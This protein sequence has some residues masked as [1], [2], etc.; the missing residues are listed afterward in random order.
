MSD[1]LDAILDTLI[2]PSGDGRMPGAGSL[3]LSATVRE[4]TREAREVVSAGLAAAEVHGFAQLDLENRVAVLRQIES[5]HPAF[6]ATLY[7]P[8]C[9]AYYQ[10]PAANEGLGLPPGPP[11][12]TGYQLE[13]GNLDA[14]ERVKKRGRLYR[15]A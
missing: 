8:A 6:I 2:P 7:M 10:H 4:Q 9:T 15:E 1:L 3:G 5:E 14:L 12:P 11:H 13:P